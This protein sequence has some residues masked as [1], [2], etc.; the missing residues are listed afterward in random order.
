[1]PKLKTLKEN[2][3]KSGFKYVTMSGSGSSFICIG[4]GNFLNIKNAK[5]FKVNFVKRDINKWY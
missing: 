4:D 2:L 5:I 3:M 1:M